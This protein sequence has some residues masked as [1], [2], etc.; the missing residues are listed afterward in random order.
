M[1]R[2]IS[3]FAKALNHPLHLDNKTGEIG[4]FEKQ[5]SMIKEDFLHYVWRL[6]RFNFIE[7]H[8]TEGEP[9]QLVYV[10][11]LNTDAGP[12]FT[13]ARIK[14]G[15]TLWAGNVEIHVQSSEWIR[16][17]HQEDMAYDN[18]ILHV[19]LEEDRPIFRKNGK[20]I[21]CLE[22]KKIIPPQ[23]SKNY[24]RLLNNE[25]WIPCQHQ[26]SKVSEI[27]KNIWLDRLLVERLEQKIEIIHQSLDNN[28]YDWE[29]S[30][31]QMLARSFGMKVNM[32]PFELLA[33]SVPLS[34]LG[35]HKNF[36]LQLEALLFGQAGMLSNDFEDHYPQKLKRE[37][38]FLQ[39]K[40]SLE[41]ILSESWKLL[42]MRPANFPTI[43]LAQL[44]H[45]LFQSTHLFSKILA[46]KNV[47]ELE[48]MFDVNVSSYWY[49]H[50][51]FDK[52]SPKR[53]KKLGKRTVHLLIINTI[54]P[55]LF[56]YGKRKAEDKYIDKALQLLEEL[57]PEQN[58]Q[59][60]QWK[61]L[62][63]LPQ[64]AYQ[65]QALLQ[66]KKTY[67]AKHRCMECSIGNAIMQG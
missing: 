43:R 13:N 53:K 62:G 55:F 34:V 8:T 38:L 37:Y 1:L 19:V 63:Y 61:A 2:S 46:A 3:S 31:Y 51:V 58:S 45:L 50:Y 17:Q 23:L 47:V 21:P 6:K 24:L 10:G 15:D 7:L 36:L 29:A 5:L 66:L 4:S 40:Y 27:T 56:A 60:N 18:V 67:C 16:H 65:S 64:S 12:D 52:I 33:K 30:F 42:R 41:P 14:I 22:L 11:E 49:T 48:H 28:K 59:I 9:I 44:A 20:R 54:V 32:E 26:F 57:P 39:K 35:K 25:Q